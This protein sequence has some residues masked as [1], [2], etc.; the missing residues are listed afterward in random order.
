MAEK[1]SELKARAHELG[2]TPDQV[3]AFGDL[4][5]RVTWEAAIAATTPG[6]D[7]ESSQITVRQLLGRADFR[8]ALD[9][10][11]W[12]RKAGYP[13]EIRQKIAR[14]GIRMHHIRQAIALRSRDPPV[15]PA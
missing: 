11:S 12:S 5:Y 4:R 13:P 6:A 2:L 9:L 7:Q 14:E 1:L 15:D 8:A 3:R 10:V